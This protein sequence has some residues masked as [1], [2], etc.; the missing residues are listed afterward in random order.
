M[1]SAKDSLTQV[2]G[3]HKVCVSFLQSLRMTE[4]KAPFVSDLI[5]TCAVKKRHCV[6]EAELS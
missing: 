3:G 6:D 1:G 2:P 4:D 5:L